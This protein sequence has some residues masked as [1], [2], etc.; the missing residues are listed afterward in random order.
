[1]DYSIQHIAKAL[2]EARGNKGLSQRELSESAGVP[3]SHISKIE[4]GNVDLRLTSLVELARALDLELTLVPRNTVPAV[5][6]I[7]RTSAP[8]TSPDRAIARK[9]HNELARLR[10]TIDHPSH[11][12]LARNQLDQFHR[13]L[14]ELQHFRLSQSDLKSIQETHKA[15]TE[16][17][18]H[19]ENRYAIE[20]SLQQIQELRNHLVHQRPTTL[21]SARPAYSLDEDDNA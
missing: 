1:M 4:N 5:Q 16:F 2:R 3:Q 7:V 10:D 9:V 21:P 14:R 11:T 15:L 19:P 18:A 6:S 17:L 8:S 13:Y 12:A 20:K